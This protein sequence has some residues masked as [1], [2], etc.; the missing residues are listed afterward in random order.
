LCSYNRIPEAGSFIKNRDLF[1]AMLVAGKSKAKG[2]TSCEGFLDESS[3]A[4]GQESTYKIE[5]ERKGAEFILLSGIHS[6][7]NNINSF[8]TTSKNSQHCCIRD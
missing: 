4:E 5:R 2:L 1:I 8:L 7:N 3:M 6:C